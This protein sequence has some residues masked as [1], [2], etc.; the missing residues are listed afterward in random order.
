MPA[1]AGEVV[2][3]MTEIRVYRQSK[4]RN[5]ML[6]VIKNITSHPTADW[7][8]QNMKSEY[9]TLS[10]GT[11]YRN[12]SVLEEQ[13]KIRKIKSDGSSDR[14]DGDTSMHSHFYCNKC[15]RVYDM[16]QVIL[17]DEF[18]FDK[19]MDG[20]KVEGFLMKYF[21]ICRDCL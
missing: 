21:G 20:H 16:D 3:N 2:D 13:G 15:R 6:N 10:L 18:G 8:Y 14:Y 11:V 9:P 1:R 19:D 12:L 17:I 4:H 5:K 7:L